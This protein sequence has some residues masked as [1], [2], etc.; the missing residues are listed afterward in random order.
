MKLN[1]F[2]EPK[3]PNKPKLSE[4]NDEGLDRKPLKK[5]EKAKAKKKRQGLR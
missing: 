1:D 5:S 3:L 4:E 2:G